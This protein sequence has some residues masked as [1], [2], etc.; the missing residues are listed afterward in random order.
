MKLLRKTSKFNAFAWLVGVLLLT[1]SVELCTS[2]GAML[3]KD[4]AHVLYAFDDDDGEMN[5]DLERGHSLMECTF[6]ELNWVRE[7]IRCVKT[8]LILA[9]ERTEI[10]EA[11][12]GVRRHRWLCR[13]SC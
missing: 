4:P 2:S 5:E 1:L 6:L 12:S 9:F 10:F 3:L 11:G 8:D 7:L 13:E